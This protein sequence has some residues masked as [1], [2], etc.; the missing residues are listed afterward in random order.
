MKDPPQTCPKFIAS[1]MSAAMVKCVLLSHFPD[2]HN[3][4][5]W[6]E[7]EEIT[8]EVFQSLTCSDLATVNIPI[9][10]RHALLSLKETNPSRLSGK[11]MRAAFQVSWHLLITTN[12]PR[13]LGNRVFQK[14][15]DSKLLIEWVL[16]HFESYKWRF[17]NRRGN[18][19]NCKK[20]LQKGKRNNRRYKFGRRKLLEM[21]SATEL[22]GTV[23]ISCSNHSHTLQVHQKLNQAGNLLHH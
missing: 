7:T 20:R 8:G 22:V 6:V 11:D 4:L 15:S 21:D 17:T 10:F 16:Q 1:N 14:R 19:L 12:L 3:N 5:D 2:L 18:S 13:M 9:G 23:I